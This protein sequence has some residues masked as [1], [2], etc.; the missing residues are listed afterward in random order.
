[1]TRPL[2]AALMLALAA[3]AGAFTL[4]ISKLIETVSNT[5]QAVVG[6]SL[7]QE[8]A[9]GR[10][11]AA[12]LVGAA[13]LVEDDAAQRYLAS[14]G[15]WVAM[16]SESP[17]LAWRFGLLDTMNVNAFAAPGGYVFVTKGLFLRLSSEDQLAG[18]LGHEISHVLRHHHAKAYSKKAGGSAAAGLLQL[19]AEA[20]DR[21]VQS[22]E[23]LTNVLKEMYASGLD[24]DDEYEAD[25]LGIVLATRAGY[26]PYGLPAVLQMYGASSGAAGFE[27]LFSTHPTPADRLTALEKA[28]GDKFDNFD[29]PT[30]GDARLK[31]IQARLG[32]GAPA[33]KPASAPT[34]P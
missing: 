23:A 28:M 11:S 31:A 13:P 25:R 33:E 7:E 20:K 34:P 18:V 5:K 16:Q 21:H 3:P 27:L 4:D 10:D 9:L 15:R 17:D 6:M 19:A 8:L 2:I 30:G 1:M 24:K 12:I 14:L 22:T 32:G 29:L 26:S